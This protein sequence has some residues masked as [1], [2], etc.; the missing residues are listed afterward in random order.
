MMQDNKDNILKDKSERSQ[1]S[2]KGLQN[3]ALIKRQKTQQERQ[4]KYDK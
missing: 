4:Y 2:K 3:K 1:V